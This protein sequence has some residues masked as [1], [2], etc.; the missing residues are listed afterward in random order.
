MAIVGRVES[1]CRYPVKSMRGEEVQQA[2]VGFAGIYGDR[3]YAFHDSGASKGFPWL[4]GRQQERML[5]YKPTFR[6]PQSAINPPNLSE[7]E[8]LSAGATPL[9]A[10]IEEMMVDVETP[11]K[12]V[13]AID[14]PALIAELSDGLGDGH[15]LSLVRS[16]RSLTDCRPVSVFSLQTIQQIG[17]EA[18]LILD[19]RRFRANIY[20]DLHM[21]A[22]SENALVGRR[23]A[24]GA[25][26][27]V[28]V[29]GLDPRCKMI[30]LDPDTAE[31]K[32]E[33]LRTVAQHHGGNAGLFGAVLTEGVVRPGDAIDLLD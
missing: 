24:L 7:A 3:V 17:R 21:A 2:F 9:Y 25:R 26:A 14:D 4:T 15:A 8:S 19:K 31:A 20:A 16:D 18:E 12:S 33:V 1:L 22:F 28:A 6:H 32:P 27:V 29:I 11:A 5:L 23:L 30:T 13:L 10:S